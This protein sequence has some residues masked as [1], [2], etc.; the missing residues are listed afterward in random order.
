MRFN[1]GE[2]HVSCILGWAM[3]HTGGCLAGKLPHGLP[4][5]GLSVGESVPLGEGRPSV[6]GRRKFPR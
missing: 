3:G 5:Q 6:E 4:C 2:R 1:K